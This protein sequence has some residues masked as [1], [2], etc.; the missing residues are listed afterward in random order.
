MTTVSQLR[1]KSNSFVTNLDKHIADVIEHNEKLLQLNKAQLKANKN[2]KGSALINNKTGSANLSPGYAKRKHKAK[3]DIFDTGATYKDMDLL[4]NEPKTWF[5]TSY[6]DYTKHLVSMYS[7]L[8][9][10]KDTN[11]AKGITTPLLT[12]LYKRL[13]LS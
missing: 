6:T 11:K 12:Q 13:V 4:F 9:G 3:P 1:K 7:D 8:F 10:I 2:A 5:I